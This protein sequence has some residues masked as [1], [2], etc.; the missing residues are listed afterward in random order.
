MWII[1]AS[2][3]YGLLVLF[4]AGI[5]TL[6][7]TKW[8]YRIAHYYCFITLTTI[9]FGDYVA[10]G[11]LKYETSEALEIL[12]DIAVVFW[13]IFGLSYFAIVISTIGK[14]EQKAAKKIQSSFNN[15]NNPTVTSSTVKYLGECANY[16]V[17]EASVQMT[18][19]D[20]IVGPVSY[21]K[22]HDIVNPNP[23]DDQNEAPSSLSGDTREVVSHH[24]YSF[25][26]SNGN[27]FT[28]QSD[29]VAADEIQG[30]GEVPPH[31]P[32]GNKV[33]LRKKVSFD[34]K[35]NP[36]DGTKKN[37]RKSATQSSKL[38]ETQEDDEGAVESDISPVSM[39]TSKTTCRCHCHVNNA[40]AES[41]S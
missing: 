32:E 5:F 19:E 40:V 39:T 28:S 6:L 17:N 4:P 27:T 38:R 10:T 12:Y 7:E 35:C 21:H 33:P 13:Y 3:S 23:P 31:A 2:I 26:N 15:P 41:T 20:G 25:N 8:T 29:L 22:S 14:S 9:G 1:V 36:N 18:L 34:S 30:A 37:Q 11:D 16:S 24:E